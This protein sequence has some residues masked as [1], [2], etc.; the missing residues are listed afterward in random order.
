MLWAAMTVPTKLP[1]PKVAELPTVQNT[2]QGREPLTKS[3]DVLAAPVNVEPT[4]N[5]QIPVELP[6]PSNVSVL[7][8]C[9][10]LQFRGKLPPTQLLL[11]FLY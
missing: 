8:S 5:T 2:L 1:P 10:A 6:A 11:Y 4:L 9:A 7:V 3:M